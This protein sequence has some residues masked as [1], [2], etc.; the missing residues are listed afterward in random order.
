M[1][2]ITPKRGK[3]HITFRGGCWNA[4]IFHSGVFNERNPKWV[5]AVK[6]VEQKN[7]ESRGS[8]TA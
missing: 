3:P 1:K 4:E 6:W 2:R 7:W 5:A 8:I